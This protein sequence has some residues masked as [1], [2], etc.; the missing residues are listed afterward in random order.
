MRLHQVEYRRCTR[1]DGNILGDHVEDATGHYW[2]DDCVDAILR[3]WHDANRERQARETID[4]AVERAEATIAPVLAGRIVETVAPAPLAIDIEEES[5]AEDESGWTVWPQGEPHPGIAQ[6]RGPGRSEPEN[7]SAIDNGSRPGGAPEETNGPD[8]ETPESAHET[9]SDGADE[10]APLRLP[11]GQLSPEEY[12]GRRD[13]L[14]LT[15]GLVA[16]RVGDRVTEAG[17]KLFAA[18][19]NDL[20]RHVKEHVAQALD[21]IERMTERERAAVRTAYARRD[22]RAASF[23]RTIADV[24]GTPVTAGKE[25]PS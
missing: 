2:H 4:A 5:A 24:T 22:K 14:G 13:A 8:P 15:D 18:G 10:P 19:R 6:E 23:A 7:E 12:A 11:D 16:W 1:C 17:L 25:G 20:G 3:I 9:Q 21:E